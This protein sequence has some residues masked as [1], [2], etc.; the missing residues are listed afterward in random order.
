ME[1]LKR[2]FRLVKPYLPMYVIA[3][4]MC[5]CAVGTRL[6]APLISR[7]LVDEVINKLSDSAAVSQELIQNLIIAL[8]LML[9]LALVRC[10][11]NYFRGWFFESV[12]QNVVFD[13]RQNMYRHLQELPF[14]FYDEHR[15]G[16][17][18]SRMTGDVEGVR[19]FVLNGAATVLDSI[20]FLTGSLF[21]LFSLSWQ[22]ALILL[23]VS[24]IVAI[25]ARMQSKRI[26]PAFS[27]IREANAVLNTRTQENL[28]GIR[29][30]KAFA[31]EDY[32]KKRFSKDNS[33]LRDA[34]LRF[35]WIRSF[36]F[37]MN[38]FISSLTSPV[39]LLVG[40]L[41]VMN[42]EVTLGTLVAVT[43]YIWMVTGP[44][45]MMG[46]I[47]DN[48]IQ[49]TTS[50]EKIFYYTDFGSY[51]K[52]KPNAKD[53]KE[54][55]GHVVF[56][57]VTFTYGDAVVLN[58]VSFDV[59][60]GKTLAIMGATGAGKTSITNLLGRFYECSEGSVTID[61]I[62][63]KDYKLSTL[64]GH[65]S[66]VFQETFL[67]SET[68]ATNIAFGNSSLEDEEIFAAAE[69]A[70]AQEFLD[71]MPDG[72]ETIVGER[73]LGL[74]GGQKQRVAIARA[75]APTP[76]ILVLDDAT[77]SVDM[78]TEYAIQKGLE[79]T[80][81]ARTTFIIAHRISSVKNADEIIVLENNTIAERG[82]HDSLMKLEGIYYQMYMD[83]YRDFEEINK[84]G[85]VI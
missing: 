51:I 85:Q 15:I 1:V 34:H 12:S 27:E 83:Q 46:N 30:V 42:G 10:F 68:I 43:N 77:S 80:A 60:P 36:Y 24:P 57:H 75:I 53:P 22:L 25:L 17:I 21:I 67:F 61:G 6:V 19:M 3:L 26:R 79:K 55:T 23:S 32:E 70:Q 28:D 35:T 65:I 45:R 29:V 20:L 18:M 40:G 33:D 72:Y 31:Q 41:L 52:D 56:D 81:N 7:F 71:E 74:S 39:L 13:I 49:A 4:V 47:I 66:Y 38:G 37:P 58:D 64:R 84:Q 59:K 69:L 14:K 48:A 8:A 73:G 9:V 11:L 62:D 5:A 82:T 54:F 76:K 63:V 44:M 2:I 50:A 16:D 78:E